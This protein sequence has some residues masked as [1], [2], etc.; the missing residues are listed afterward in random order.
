MNLRRYLQDSILVVKYNTK[1]TFRTS[2]PNLDSQTLFTMPFSSEDSRN[3]FIS[4]YLKANGHFQDI[5]GIYLIAFS[6]PS[7]APTASKPV[8]TPPT[9]SPAYKSPTRKPTVMPYPSDA[10]GT[11]VKYIYFLSMCLMLQ[12]SFDL[13]VV[14]LWLIFAS[15]KLL[16]QSLQFI[17]R[18]K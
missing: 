3:V 17:P 4:Q 12:M 10:P 15:K 1:M 8:L 16:G 5:T 7:F 18:S 14:L 9:L 13:L 6:K 2:D 11:F